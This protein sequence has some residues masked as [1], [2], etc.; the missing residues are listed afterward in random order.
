MDMNTELLCEDVKVLVQYKN[1]VDISNIV[2]KTDIS[3]KIIYVNEEFC[4]ISG[5]SKVELIGKSHN[6]VRHSDMPNQVFKELWSTILSKEI[7][8]GTIKNKAKNGELYVVNTTIVP[9]LDRSGN[10]VEFISIRHDITELVMLRDKFKERSIKDCLTGIYNRSFFSEVI[11]TEYK[12]MIQ[13]EG[14]CSLI[15]F[16]IDNFK[17]INDQFGHDS[18]DKLLIAFT[19]KIKDVIREKDV[20]CRIGGDEFAIIVCDISLKKAKMIAEKIRMTIAEATFDN[21]LKITL[22]FGITEFNFKDSPETI[23][24]CADTALYSAKRKGRNCIELA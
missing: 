20:F 3:G 17:Q 4:R 2:S 10:I 19:K 15:L 12:R 18:G 16:D 9:I 11:E 5:Y 1:I 24:T 14:S 23:Y 6:V 22:S 21:D 7:W 8:K 13:G